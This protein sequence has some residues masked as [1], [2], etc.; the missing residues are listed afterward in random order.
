METRENIIESLFERVETYGKTTIELSKL[1]I[2]DTTTK[3]FT[4]L[5]SRLSVIV[6]ISV[7]VL[8]LSIGVA[9]FLG[10]ILGKAYYGFFIVAGLYLLA[11][12]VFY[13]FLRKWVQKPLSE[14]IIKQSLQ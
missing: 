10:D 9:L 14:M 7:F 8:V 13:Y 2:L 1:K 5:I 3:V 11:G 12:I 6:M 4:T